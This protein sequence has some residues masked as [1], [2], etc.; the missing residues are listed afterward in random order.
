MNIKE[1]HELI[2]KLLK[3][4]M[5]KLGFLDSKYMLAFNLLEFK[6]T[7]GE[8]TY[9]IRLS[10]YNDTIGLN[11]LDGYV[12][13]D[14]VNKILKIFID[15][16]RNIEFITLKDYENEQSNFKKIDALNKVSKLKDISNYVND[17]VTHIKANI[18]PFFTKY[19]DMETINEEILNKVPESEYKK[20]IHGEKN[21]KVLIIMKLCDNPNYQNFKLWA[22]ETYKNAIKLDAD[23]YG[24]D[25]HNLKSLIKYLDSGKYKE[26]L[27]NKN[28][29]I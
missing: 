14:S 10:L 16:E 23:R 22:E 9:L 27:E 20:Y 1:K 7:V 2:F 21:F 25:F 15:L 28:E 24:Q 5:N 12:N 26:V 8:T 29:I 3:P 19:P 11:S 4:L 18:I 17:I 13:L 6:Q